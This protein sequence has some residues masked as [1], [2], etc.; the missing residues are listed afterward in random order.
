MPT[1]R[2]VIAQI[3]KQFGAGTMRLASD[4]EYVVKYLPTGLA[5]IDDLFLGG[6]P[7]GRH[8]M[9][10]GD[11]STLK[12]YVGLCAIASAQ[13]RGL[14]AALI[15]TENSFDPDW[16][17]RLGVDLDQLVMPPKAKIE[18]GEKAIDMAE[19]LIRGGV[20]LLVFDSIAAALPQAEWGQSMEGKTQ[21]ARQAAMF[22]MGMRKLTA[23][24]RKTAILWINQT[25][26]NP[27][28]AFGNPEVV[29]AGKAI[30]FYC[31]YIAGFY[32]G[33]KATE[34]IEVFMPDKD[35]R[36]AKKKVKQTIGYEVRVNLYKSK[37]NK[38]FREE[39]FVY[40]LK[41]G[42][43]DEWLY[44]ANKALNMGLL[45]YE[46]G[47]WWDPSD[48]KKLTAEVFRGHLPLP[49][50]KKLLHGTVT[51]VESAGEAP[52][53]SKKAVPPKRRS[54]SG[55][56]RKRTATP[57]PVANISSTAVTST[58]LLKSKTQKKASVSV[59]STSS[60]S[61]RKRRVVVAKGS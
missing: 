56:T 10:H 39:T 48:G 28:M 25:R 40:S 35:G 27:G 53:A 49:E 45:G 60:G 61:V 8:V 20:D 18:T 38:P 26:I 50:L 43:V 2:E 24:N 59:T 22:S 29:P 30:P 55:T 33:A 46:R 44:L 15:D 31:T 9:I 7:F 12:S 58:K 37:L 52:R 17:K 41:H 57:A 6:L 32:K 42:A 47:R 3:N 19:S 11:Y 51:G 1:A 14:V 23:A 34:E 36:P 21:L 13:K 54:S 16:A 4:P 5:P